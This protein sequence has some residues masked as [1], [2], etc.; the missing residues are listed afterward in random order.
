MRSV[1]ATSKT[2]WLLA[3]YYRFRYSEDYQRFKNIKFEVQINN[4]R[5]K[6]KT[7]IVQ[8]GHILLTGVIT[9]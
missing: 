5:V 6:M 3:P 7:E 4:E 1:I 8:Y 9:V 2:S